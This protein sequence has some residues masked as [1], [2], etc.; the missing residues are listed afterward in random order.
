MGVIDRSKYRAI[1]KRC[2]TW[3]NEP[4][5]E[6]RRLDYPF[7]ERVMLDQRILLDIIEFANDE[8]RKERE[9]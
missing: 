4:I 9:K 3:L 2:I 5:K 7:I 8:L 6:M 1:E